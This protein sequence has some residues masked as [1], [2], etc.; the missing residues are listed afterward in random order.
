[1][2]NVC[3]YMHEYNKLYYIANQ[4]LVISKT[5]RPKHRKVDLPGTEN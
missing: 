2:T 4:T 5:K 1:M 3:M